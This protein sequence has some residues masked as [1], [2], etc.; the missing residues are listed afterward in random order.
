M[1]Q[2]YKYPRTSHIFGSKLQ[3]GDED[4]INVPFEQIKG[5]NIVVEEKVDGANSG[6]SV[7][8]DKLMLQSRG[9]YLTG[10]YRERHFDLFKTWA[11]C[12]TNQLKDLLCERYVIYGE[13]LFAKHTVFYDNLPHYWM[14]FDILDT[15]TNTFFDTPRRMNMLRD[16]PFI[17]SVK[18]LF[19]GK[20]DKKQD[21]YDMVKNS[22]FI[23]D[24]YKKNLETESTKQN[25]NVEKIFNETD[26]SNLMEGL[27]IKVEED[28]IVKERYK[29]V[30]QG[31]LQ[32]VA[33]SESHWLDRPIIPNKLSCNINDL[34][35]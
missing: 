34:F 9:H 18:V 27:Y 16:F 33:D 30:R 32:V 7:V 12:W 14:E 17:H 35:I 2:I 15:E 6:I 3:K 26:L 24:D 8:N 23:S 5:R 4:L 11:N 13:Y 10:G 20:L 19:E 22:Y 25:L 31:F 29:F 28:G 21:L 1:K